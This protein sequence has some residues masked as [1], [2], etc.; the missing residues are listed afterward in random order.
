MLRLPLLGVGAWGGG[1]RTP[2]GIA[3]GD[4][5][6]LGEAKPVQVRAGAAD[7]DSTA[8]GEARPVQA[9]D[10]AADG[11]STALAESV[12][13]GIA[14]G[15]STAMGEPAGAGVLS[16][17]ALAAMSGLQVWLDP[18]NTSDITY[19]G[20][21]VAAIDP[22]AGALTSSFSQGTQNYQ[23]DTSADDAMIFDGSDDRIAYSGTVADFDFLNTDDCTLFI[24]AKFDVLTGY[25]VLFTTFGGDGVDLRNFNGT[26]DFEALVYNDSV[27]VSLRSSSLPISTGDFQIFELHIDGT[28]ASIHVDGAQVDSDTFTADT[29]VSINAA[30]IGRRSALYFDGEVGDVIAFNRALTAQEKTDIRDKMADKWGIT[31]P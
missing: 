17:A 1:M 20:S 21:L 22:R 10:G 3:I 5:F 12:F 13:E 4:S 31:L 14:E 2:I 29:G 18:K 6:A 16:D 15:T 28:T 24:V 11:D 7:G 19:N 25:G 9:R 27:S 30:T 23:P 26:A 8:I